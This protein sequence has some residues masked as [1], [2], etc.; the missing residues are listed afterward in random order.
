LHVVKWLLA[1]KELVA[2]VGS[3]RKRGWLDRIMNVDDVDARVA[4]WLRSPQGSR[5][6]S[7]WTLA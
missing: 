4:E 7:A 5:V 2:D 6:A 3:E 1:R